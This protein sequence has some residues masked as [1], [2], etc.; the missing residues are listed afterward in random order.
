M[1][2][3]RAV[4]IVGL[5]STVFTEGVMAVYREVFDGSLAQYI[6]STT[7]SH[8]LYIF[9]ES[10]SGRRQSVVFVAIERAATIVCPQSVGSTERVL[11]VH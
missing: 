4:T 5:Q 10:K 11:A 1:T 2:V 8:H 7:F 6:P 9:F 3:G